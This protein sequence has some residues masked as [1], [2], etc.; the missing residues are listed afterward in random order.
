MNLGKSFG[1]VIIPLFSGLNTKFFT[2]GVPKIFIPSNGTTA[3]KNPVAKI[4]PFCVGNNK[5][6]ANSISHKLIMLLQT[7]ISPLSN[8]GIK[9]VFNTLNILF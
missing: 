1:T 6:N 4:T 2:A 7:L 5:S 9:D 3:V 8:V